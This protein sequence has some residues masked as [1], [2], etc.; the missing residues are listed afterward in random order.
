[1]DFGF[2]NW[3]FF[4]ADHRAL[5]ARIESWSREQLGPLLHSE[6]YRWALLD[7]QCRMI[8]NALGES[9]LLDICAPEAGPEG[10]DVRLICLAREIL[11]RR[12]SLAEF[13]LA[14]QGLGIGPIT[15]FG[16]NEQRARYLP[17][18]RSGRSIAAFAL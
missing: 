1:L 10:F 15:L 14:M 7:A 11:A 2:L 8:A 9:G 4:E 3:P 17:S 6:A 16:S 18:V 5:A 13:V 12:S